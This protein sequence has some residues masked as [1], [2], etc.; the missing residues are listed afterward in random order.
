MQ[1]QNKIGCVYSD[2]IIQM[3]PEVA[4]ANI[5]LKKYQDSLAN[6]AAAF[7]KAFN[8]KMQDW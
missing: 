2:N 4:E 7:E 1:A 5:V 6:S 3:M 8:K